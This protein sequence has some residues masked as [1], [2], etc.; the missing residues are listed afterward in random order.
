MIRFLLPF[1]IEH[2]CTQR[3]KCSRW[4]PGVLVLARVT[5]V[6]C[7]QCGK[8]CGETW[9]G[10]P[11]ILSLVLRICGSSGFFPTAVWQCLSIVYCADFTTL[12]DH[13]PWDTRH[14]QL[15]KMLHQ[16]VNEENTKVTQI[17]N[18]G[19]G[20][21][22][23]F[24]LLRDMV[25]LGLRD[26]EAKGAWLLGPHLF[27]RKKCIL[28]KLKYVLLLQKTC[29]VGLCQCCHCN[30][31]LV[32]LQNQP[33]LRFYP[34][35]RYAAKLR[36]QWVNMV[37]VSGSVARTSWVKPWPFPKQAVCS[38]NAPGGISVPRWNNKK[39]P[40]NKGFLMQ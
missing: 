13:G 34:Q 22:I 28:Q 2:G 32:S 31:L 18:S 38:T 29:S 39:M 40:D 36:V 5:N 11:R 16:L 19:L 35:P 6:C 25:L 37:M 30:I 3:I 33:A 21:G 27:L 8:W 20:Y 4:L 23:C 15:L 9:E 17:Q 1:V 24:Y 26:G 14:R 12:R 7:S 10:V